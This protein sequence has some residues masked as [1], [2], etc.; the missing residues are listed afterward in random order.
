ST[1]PASACDA[2]RVTISQDSVVASTPV[3]GSA[4]TN[5]PRWSWRARVTA[6]ALTLAALLVMAVAYMWFYNK[7]PLLDDYRSGYAVGGLWRLDHQ[8]GNR[9]DDAG[10]SLYSGSPTA[11]LKTGYSAF[12]SGCRDG[13]GGKSP[14]SWWNLRSRI[15]SPLG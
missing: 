14:A 5:L 9:C 2:K 1:A 4:Y 11:P 15:V 7:L 10:A 6:M 3:D 12:V 8:R 13:L